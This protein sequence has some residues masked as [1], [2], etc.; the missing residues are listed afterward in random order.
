MSPTSYQAAPLRDIGAGSRGRTGTRNKSHGILSPG[1]LPIPPF[2]HS[3]SVNAYSI[4]ARISCFVNRFFGILCAFCG[5]TDFRASPGE[6]RRGISDAFVGTAGGFAFCFRFIVC[7]GGDSYADFRKDNINNE[8]KTIRRRGRNFRRRE[9]RNLHESAGERGEAEK[10]RTGR[11]GRAFAVRAAKRKEKRTPRTPPRERFP[12][13]NCRKK[14]GENFAR[15][16]LG[17]K[18][19]QNF[20]AGC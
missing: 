8:R 7:G 5:K 20:N 10:G 14:R 15:E 9:V 4:I 6:F 13:K 16:T 17:G 18:M 2:R 12:A 1:R 19:R 3:A 11:K